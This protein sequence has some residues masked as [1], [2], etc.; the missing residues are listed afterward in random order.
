MPV[1]TFE[2]YLPEGPFSALGANSDLCKSKL[3]MPTEFLAQNGAVIKRTTKIAVN[4]C[5]V[6]KR[7]TKKRKPAQAKRRGKK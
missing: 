1:N 3:A 6:S 4:G 5:V 7:K 2:L